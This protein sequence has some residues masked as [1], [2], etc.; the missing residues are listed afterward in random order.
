LAEND[1]FLL[2]S[3]QYHDPDSFLFS[4]QLGGNG[5][6]ASGEQRSGWSVDRDA[7]EAAAESVS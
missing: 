7:P 1:L 4:W 6:L 2:S 5:E 3:F